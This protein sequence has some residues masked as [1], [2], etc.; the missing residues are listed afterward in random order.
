MIEASKSGISIALIQEPYVG[1]VGYMKDYRG[2]QLYQ[3][4]QRSSGVVKTAIAVFNDNISDTQYPNLTTNNLTVVKI[5]M[6]VREVGVISLYLE[7]DIPIE[8]YMD[9]LRHVLTKIGKIEV[10]IGGDVKA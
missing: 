1:G 5:G 8:P 9:H 7:P 3:C 4:A 2:A 6:G 10:L